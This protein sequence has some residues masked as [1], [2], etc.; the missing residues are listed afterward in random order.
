MVSVDVC[1]FWRDEYSQEIK[2][3]SGIIHTVPAT[4]YQDCLNRCDDDVK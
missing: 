3:Q 2:G 4:G 1:S